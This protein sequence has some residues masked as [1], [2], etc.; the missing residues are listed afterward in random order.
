MTYDPAHPK[1]EDAAL[2]DRAREIV[3]AGTLP[4][5][6]PDRVWGGNGR[7][8]EC[9]ICATPVSQDEAECE[10]EFARSGDRP[11]HDVYHLHARC[12]MA[13]ESERENSSSPPVISSRGRP[14]RKRRLDSNDPVTT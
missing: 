8:A 7:G 11:G 13:W 10:I 6:R 14:A 1:G 5:R 12:F 4:N 3:Q 9:V 2:R